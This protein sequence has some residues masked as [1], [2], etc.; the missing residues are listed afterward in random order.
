MHLNR[1]RKENM[2]PSNGIS[3]GRYGIAMLVRFFPSF[4][5]VAGSAHDTLCYS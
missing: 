3:Q 1:T 2:K 4:W 5:E